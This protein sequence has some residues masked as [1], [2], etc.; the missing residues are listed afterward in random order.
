MAA[1]KFTIQLET[2]R[3]ND[4]IRRLTSQYPGRVNTI[5]KAY[6]FDLLRGIIGNTAEY[7][8]PV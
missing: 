7:R 5:L 3:F 1:P 8:H 4:H 6:A 2:Q